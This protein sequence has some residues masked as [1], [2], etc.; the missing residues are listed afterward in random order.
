MYSEEQLNALAE[1]TGF[2]TRKSKLTPSMFVDTV[3]FKEMNNA[4]VS[5]EDHCVALKQRYN[6]DIKKQ[7][8]AERFNDTA[9]KF[10]RELLNRHLSDQIDSAIER[11]K[12][13][14]ILQHFTSVKLQD[15]TRFQVPECLKEYYPG[16]TGASTGAGVHIQFEFDVLNGKVDCLKVTDALRADS[17]EAEETMDAIETGGL[18]IRD[19]GYYTTG[20]LE[21]IHE[22]G[23]YFISRTK[24]RTGFIDSKTGE[25]IDFDNVY[26][27]MK[28]HKF[29][30]IEFAVSIGKQTPCRLIVEMLPDKVVQKRLAQAGRRAKKKGK[31][32]SDE[33]RSRVRLNLFITN[34]PIEW[35]ATTQVR[36]LYQLRWQIEL[37]FK[38]WKSYYDL[39][40]VKKMQCHRFECYLYATLLLLMINLEIAINFFSILWKYT[41]SPLS[42]LKF[43]KTTSQYVTVIRK[44]IIEGSEEIR[45][46]L[47]FLY[48][49]SYDKLLTE[50]RKNHTGGLEEILT[51]NILA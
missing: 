8:L 15:S 9:V 11:S 49:V 25:K 29:S 47:A 2:K 42:L 35:I 48:E 37:R 51:K 32:L 45:S 24:P 10:I 33:Y 14:N 3:M 38:A 34:I 16:S 46:H 44:G 6:M 28:R 36:Q 23:A 27:R 5:L 40:A 43:Y 31:T 20:T 13:G 12:L 30:H 21:H 22:K 50:R 41:S 26:R 4:Q 1:E 19:L 39:E 17:T 7:S 18:I